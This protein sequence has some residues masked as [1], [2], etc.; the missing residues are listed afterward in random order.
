MR[1]LRGSEES[2]PVELCVTDLRFTTDKPLYASGE[3]IHVRF[4]NSAGDPIL[5]WQFNK[6]ENERGC[7]GFFFT[8]P[9]PESEIELNC[10]S[11]DNTVELYL[12][13]RNAYG[14]YT[15]DRVVVKK[16]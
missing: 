9:L 2:D 12:M 3:P 6:T 14:I 13:A 16:A 15:S 4:S 11:V 7:G 5:A 1:A 8:D 10:P